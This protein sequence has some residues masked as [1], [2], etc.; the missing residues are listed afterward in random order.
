MFIQA[1]VYDQI[2]SVFRSKIIAGF[3]LCWDYRIQWWQIWIRAGI[4]EK[5]KVRT[6]YTSTRY[7]LEIAP[8]IAINCSCTSLQSLLDSWQLYAI[9]K[10]WLIQTGYLMHRKCFCTKNWQSYLTSSATSTA[11]HSK[12]AQKYSSHGERNSIKNPERMDP[13]R[14]GLLKQNGRYLGW[15]PTGAQ[16]QNFPGTSNP[17]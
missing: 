17:N 11:T 2:F 9:S 16:S 4:K 10:E 1:V 6:K 7:L 12:K 14:V 15:K 13:C 8:M 3:D 5:V